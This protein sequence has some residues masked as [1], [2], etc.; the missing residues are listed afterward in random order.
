M[1]GHYP[2]RRGGGLHLQKTARDRDWLLAS[3]E[4]YNVAGHA[5]EPVPSHIRQ[6]MESAGIRV[7]RSCTG[8]KAHA[9]AIGGEEMSV[10]LRMSAEMH[11]R[12]W[13]A[14]SRENRSV[15]G[16]LLNL[17]ERWTEVVLGDMAA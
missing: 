9:L 15:P 16:I 5:Y 1:S 10:T 17:A 8:A 6:A 14:A 2:A 12:L 11:A 3:I 4:A 7:P 13:G